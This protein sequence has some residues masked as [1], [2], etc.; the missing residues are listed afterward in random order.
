M[1]RIRE[2]REARGWNQKDLADRISSTRQAV[3][4]YETGRRSPDLETLGMLC[5]VF[6]VTADYLLGR[7]EVPTLEISAEEWQLVEAFRGL[8]PEGQSYVRHS[9][10]LAG[11]GHSGKNRDVPGLDLKEA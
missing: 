4:H 9:L 1:I 2:L 11:L 6:G 10:A 8:S 3:G 5:D 7:S